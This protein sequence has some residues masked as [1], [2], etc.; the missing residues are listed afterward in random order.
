MSDKLGEQKWFSLRLDRC[1]GASY[2][3]SP[4]FMANRNVNEDFR[5]RCAVV[6]G[7]CKT[8]TNSTL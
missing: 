8:I 3:L 2:F 6:Q 7:Y 1:R 5:E 4:E